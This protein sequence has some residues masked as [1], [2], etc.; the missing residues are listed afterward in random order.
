MVTQDGEERAGW[1]G[2]KGG[3]ER[4]L[5]GGAS[6]PRLQVWTGGLGVSCG[7]L[8]MEL[9]CPFQEESYLGNSK[10]LV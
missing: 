7:G 10:H 5:G 2:R 3:Q 4:L 8:G 9:G 6:K 1:Y